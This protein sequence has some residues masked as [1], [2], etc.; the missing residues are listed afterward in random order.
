[1]QRI[2]SLL[3]KVSPAKR[4]LIQP[5]ARKFGNS[6]KPTT[7]NWNSYLLMGAGLSGMAYLTY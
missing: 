4:L 3:T 7:S 5:L 2:S 1:M 6:I